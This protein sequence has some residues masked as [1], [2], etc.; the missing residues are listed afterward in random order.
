MNRLFFQCPTDRDHHHSFYL[1]LKTCPHFCGATGIL[2]LYDEAAPIFFL[3]VVSPAGYFVSLLQDQGGRPTF[4]P[5][6][7]SLP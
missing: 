1:C 7:L 2:I 3:T 4:H 5:E 6:F